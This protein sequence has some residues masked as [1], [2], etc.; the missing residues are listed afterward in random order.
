MATVAE[1][2]IDFDIRFPEFSGES[3]ARKTLYIEDAICIFNCCDKA[4][5]YLAAHLLTL[6]NAS[7]AGSTGG[8]VDGG[9]G[10]VSS[11][12]VGS[13][14]TSYANQAVAGSK[15]VY[16]ETTPYGRRYIQLRNAC[17]GYRVSMIS[18]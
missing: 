3:E 11:E 14:N 17:S 12:A 5:I 9:N 18:I 10:L 6:D 13:V 8:D 7:G 16:Y 4:I 1:L 2:L 15:D